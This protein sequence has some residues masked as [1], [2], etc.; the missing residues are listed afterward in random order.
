MGK[1]YAVLWKKRGVKGFIKLNRAKAFAKTK[2]NKIKAKVSIDKITTYP[3]AK[4]GMV[5]WSQKHYMYVKPK[6]RK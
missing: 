4:P 5:D 1:R 3:K 2:A 6:K